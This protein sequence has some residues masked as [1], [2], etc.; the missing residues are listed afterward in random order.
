MTEQTTIRNAKKQELKDDD[1]IIKLLLCVLN[2]SLSLL[3]A[4]NEK[5]SIQFFLN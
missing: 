5:Y 1:K 4:L 2:V 3:L